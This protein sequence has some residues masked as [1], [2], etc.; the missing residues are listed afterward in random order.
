M[1]LAKIPKNDGEYIRKKLFKLG[2]VRKDYKIFENE[3]FIYLPLRE[4]PDDCLLYT[5]DAADE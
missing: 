3:D 5:S 2:L 1:I 4:L